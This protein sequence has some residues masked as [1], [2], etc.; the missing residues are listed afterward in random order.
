MAEGDTWESKENLKNVKELV[1]EFEREYGEEAECKGNNQ[2]LARS[3]TRELSKSPG[4]WSDIQ[5]EVNLPI[6]ALIYT[7]KNGLCIVM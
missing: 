7:T 3:H 4:S 1:E 6:Q 5:V 2:Q